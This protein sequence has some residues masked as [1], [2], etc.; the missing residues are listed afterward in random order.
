MNSES[1][2]VHYAQQFNRISTMGICLKNIY[3][4]GLIISFIHILSI[5][6]IWADFR[7]EVGYI[8]DR[9]LIYSHSYIH[10]YRHF[11]AASWPCLHVFEL[12]AEIKAPEGT[13]ADTVKSC[14]VKNGMFKPCEMTVLAHV[15]PC[16]LL[17]KII[18]SNIQHT[19]VQKCTVWNVT[20]FILNAH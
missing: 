12:C 17:G 4:P 2:K 16:S 5:P 19:M 11:K 7:E 6:L 8:R 1:P 9:S 3:I 18:I 20:H 10:T 14:R 13:Y 15:P